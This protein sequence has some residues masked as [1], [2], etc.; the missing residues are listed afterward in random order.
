[1]KRPEY[2]IKEIWGTLRSALANLSFSRIKRV[3]GVGGIDIT[4]LAQFVQEGPSASS[5]ETLLSAIDRQICLLPPEK[6]EQFVRITAEELI[7]HTGDLMEEL[8]DPRVEFLK[9]QAY[10]VEPYQ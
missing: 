9:R 1:M 3:A 6:Q 7:A 10:A 5:K 2:S 8:N 4:G